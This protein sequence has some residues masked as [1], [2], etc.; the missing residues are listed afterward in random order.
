MER[1]HQ[2]LHFWTLKNRTALGE[3]RTKVVQKSAWHPP[4]LPLLVS[5]RAVGV[6]GKREYPKATLTP[7]WIGD[8][9]PYLLRPRNSRGADGSYCAAFLTYPTD[10][11]WT[12]VGVQRKQKAR[13]G[14]VFRNCCSALE[15]STPAVGCVVM[16]CFPRCLR[17]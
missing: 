9:P 17:A 12:A 2:R 10:L 4:M 8:H 11:T 7:K 1:T 3:K 5:S 15:L 14:K 6:R 13:E 16:M